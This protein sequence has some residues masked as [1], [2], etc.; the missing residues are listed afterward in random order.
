MQF[1]VTN[2]APADPND[3]DDPYV[4]FVHGFNTVN[5]ADAGSF[6]FDWTVLGPEGNMTAL[7]PA[8]AAIGT[9]G[10]VNVEW[11]GLFTGIAEKQVGAVSH[12]DDAGIQGLTIVN[13]DNDGDAGYS[14]ICAAAPTFCPL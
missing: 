1:P 9:T 14:D 8:S 4:V 10:T 5:N 3:A 13:I 2:G 12:S 7:G 6:M 11:T